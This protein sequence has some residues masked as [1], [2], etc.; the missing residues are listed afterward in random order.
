MR[1]GY[2]TGRSLG[3]GLPGAKRVMDEFEIVS[4]MGKG[5]TISM[6]KWTR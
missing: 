3:V 5:T 4:T 6:K 1:D 2:S